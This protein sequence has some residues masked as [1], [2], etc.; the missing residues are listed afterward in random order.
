MCEWVWAVLLQVFSCRIGSKSKYSTNLLKT[1]FCTY[2][3]ILLS[4]SFDRLDG[5]QHYKSNLNGLKID[6]GNL[7]LHSAM[8]IVHD[9]GVLGCSSVEQQQTRDQSQDTKPKWPP[10]RSRLQ[11]PGSLGQ[12][13]RNWEGLFKYYVILSLLLHPAKKGFVKE[14]T[15]V[16]LG[17]TQWMGTGANEV[18]K[19]SLPNFA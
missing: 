7:T 4:S 1:A 19:T 10:L 8:S 3:T 6:G 9:D 17:R 15:T 14:N 5:I 11:A 18:F 13:A 16:Q 2:I 12:A